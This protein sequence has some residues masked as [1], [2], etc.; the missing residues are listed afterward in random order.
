[1]ARSETGLT[2]ANEPLLACL[3]EWLG[4]NR[5]YPTLESCLIVDPYP[6]VGR[7]EVAVIRRGQYLCLYACRLLTSATHSPSSRVASSVPLG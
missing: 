6:K 7:G 1:M 5:F 4:G 2:R 3:K